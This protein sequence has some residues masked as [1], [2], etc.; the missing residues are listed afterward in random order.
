MKFYGGFKLGDTSIGIT[1]LPDRKRPCLYI[2]E[3]GVLYPV[4]YFTREDFA[5]KF[6]EELKRFVRAN[7]NE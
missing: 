6:W 4:A 1:H 2:Q 5:E 3:G 7:C